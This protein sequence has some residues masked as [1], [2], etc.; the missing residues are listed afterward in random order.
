M[1]K[2][3]LNSEVNRPFKEQTYGFSN[4]FKFFEY[5]D[6]YKSCVGFYKTNRQ[7]YIVKHKKNAVFRTRFALH[8]RLAEESIAR[9]T[10][11]NLHRLLSGSSCRLLCA[12]LPRELLVLDIRTTTYYF[13]VI[14]CLVVQP[15]ASGWAHVAWS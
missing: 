4:Q 6:D 11:T 1:F 8:C 3:C 9:L 14:A 7:F 5:V 12:T 2:N 15:K 13:F 10:Y